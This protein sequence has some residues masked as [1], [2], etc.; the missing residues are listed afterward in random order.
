[1]GYKLIKLFTRG[2]DMYDV[3]SELAKIQGDLSGIVISAAATAIVALITLFVNFLTKILTDCKEYNRTQQDIMKNFYPKLKSQILY[4]NLLIEELNKDPLYSTMPKMYNDYDSFTKNEKQYRNEHQTEL[5]HIDSFI[6]KSKK[7][8]ANMKILNE[9]FDNSDVPQTPLYHP[10]LKYQVGKML[11]CMQYHSFLVLQ[12]VNNEISLDVFL[13][14]INLLYSNKKNIIN[15]DRLKRY[16][17]LL[18]KWYLK[19]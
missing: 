17:K 9:F 1:M 3:L 16:T 14:E 7:W 12:Y 8:V 18:Y 2:N 13:Y 6:T 19:Y 4:L 15:N 11:E 5:K 10:I